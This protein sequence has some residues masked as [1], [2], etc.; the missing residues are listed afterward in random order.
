[1]D[2]E[3]TLEF[4]SRQK[5]RRMY[6]G[7]SLRSAD[8]RDSVSG[9]TDQCGLDEPRFEGDPCGLAVFGRRAVTWRPCNLLSALPSPHNDTLFDR[10]QPLVTRPSHAL[11]EGI[12]LIIVTT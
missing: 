3:F 9:E 10:R 12:D 7:P 8:Q 2:A 1:M 4:H 11:N 5:L 6:E